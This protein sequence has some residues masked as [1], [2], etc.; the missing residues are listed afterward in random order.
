MKLQFEE[1][2]YQQE[3]IAAALDLFAGQPRPDPDSSLPQEGNELLLSDEAL[4]ENLNA[5]QRRSGL[6]ET[7][8]A[9]HGLNFTV[10]METGTGKT[11]VYLRTLYEL[12]RRYGWKKFLIVVPSVVIREGVMHSLR[13]MQAHFELLFGGSIGNYGVYDSRRR[14]QLRDFFA[15]SQIEILILNIQTFEKDSNVINREN[16][17]G[18]R[19]LELLRAARPIVIIDEPQNLDSVKRQEA[20]RSLTPL[21]TLGYSA[22]HKNSFHKIFSLN[23][24][25]AYQRRLVKQIEVLGLEASDGGNGA[26]VEVQKIDHDSRQQLVAQVALNVHGQHGMAR[27]VVRVRSGDDLFQLSKGN[28]A[29]RHG[30]IVDGLDLE[31]QEIQ[32]S[33]G[34]RPGLG[35]D[36]RL[37][38][39]IMKAQIRHTIREHLRREK[40][41]NP[42]GIK[43]LSLFFIDRVDNYRAADGSPGPLARWFEACYRE[44]S[45]SDGA[46]VHN[47]YFSRDK[48]GRARDTN[49][50]SA[51]DEDTYQLIMRDKEKL[52]SLANPL[53][54]I[55]SHSALKEGWDNPNVFQICTL[56]QSHS[57][58]KKRQEIGR[59]LRLAVNQQ[60]QRV[61]DEDVNV[62]TVI[63]NESYQSFARG[64][65]QEYEDECGIPFKAEL[66]RNARQRQTLRYRPNFSID[67]QFREIWHRLKTQSRYRVH[68]DSEELIRRASVALRQLPPFPRP[69]IQQTKARLQPSDGGVAGREI[70]SS[71]SSLTLEWE[72]PDLLGEIQ[73]Q[74]HLTRRT[75]AAILTGS[76]RLAEVKNN[77]QHFIDA[78]TRA[79]NLCLQELMVAGI[80]YEP[81]RQRY[82]RQLL[83]DMESNGLDFQPNEYTFRVSRPEKTIY[84][85]QLP[86]DS[87]TELQFARDC[88][89]YGADDGGVLFYFKLPRWFQI[90][91]PLGH[92]NPDW[93]VVRQFTGPAA[94][95]QKVYF[96]A[97][98]KNTG[99]P[100]V[101]ESALRRQER[102]KIDCARR[103]FA[104]QGDLNYRVV[105][106]LR[107]L[108]E[109]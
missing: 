35:S 26:L 103:Y 16:E 11:Y 59:G 23:P 12:N 17:R 75:L 89:N 60:G 68:L 24:V 28:E 3:A 79:I 106:Q 78:A 56:N 51:D 14:G 69:K 91:T 95:P 4:Q 85:D 40:R 92:Y 46:D 94:R 98:T 105:Q 81:T 93:A 71:S 87:A 108:E 57:P 80:E 66:V 109:E 99:G 13:Q 100:A 67:P 90:P 42:R 64:L 30:F 32:L 10:E 83:E 7:P 34:H 101:D 63:A 61:R 82:S 22:T 1:L 49:G 86:L 36:E 50:R 53:R 29:Y 96:I 41:L 55:F 9:E 31:A 65:Q 27:K 84:A 48:S 47:G 70:A 104:S 74:T 37:R 19:P 20:L 62:L 8:L 73:R 76:G 54:F 39:E 18:D 58:I 2:D 102:L 107:E 25:Q 44:E 72:L 6:P 33:N 52:L 38:D 45:G 5:V 15:S 88:E 43:V 77:P 97:E 21:F